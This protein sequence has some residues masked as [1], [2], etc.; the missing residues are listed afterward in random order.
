MRNYLKK[1]VNKLFKFIIKKWIFIKV[2]WMFRVIFAEL[3]KIFYRMNVLNWKFH[4][5]KLI[6]LLMKFKKVFMKDL[7]LNK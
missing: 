1:F 2:L 3:K 4:N 5:N 7:I 6:E